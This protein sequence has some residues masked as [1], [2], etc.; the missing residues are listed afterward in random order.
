MPDEPDFPERG[1]IVRRLTQRVC[2]SEN[3]TT[4]IELMIAMGLLMVIA[5]VALGSITL[6][7]N[8]QAN[9]YARTASISQAQLIAEAVTRAVRNAN[10]VTVPTDTPIIEAS[11]YELYFYQQSYSN[12]TNNRISVIWLA[13]GT[14][15]ASAPPSLFETS[16]PGCSPTTPCSVQE[17]IYTPPS[18]PAYPVAYPPTV[19]GGFTLFESRNLGNEIVFSNSSPTTTTNSCSSAAFSAG[20]SVSTSITTGIGI[21]QFYDGCLNSTSSLLDLQ[22]IGVTLQAQYEVGK[23]LVS[24][25]SYVQIRNLGIGS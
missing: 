10:N 14:V 2:S 15:S 8:Q 7:E 4:L 9:T 3:G 5:A 23:P 11:P 21:F 6:A 13:G 18:S 12:P 1:L 20:G 25:T 17:N 16:S 19:M 22:T 24:V